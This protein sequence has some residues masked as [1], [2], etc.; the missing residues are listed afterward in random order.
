MTITKHHYLD[1]VDGEFPL[2]EH[3]QHFAAHVARG[4]DHGD[5]VTH[6]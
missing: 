2:G 6:R 1:L 5:L 4:A 3:V